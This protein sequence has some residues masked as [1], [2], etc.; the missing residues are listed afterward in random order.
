MERLPKTHVFVFFCGNQKKNEFKKEHKEF[1]KNQQDQVK[2]EEESEWKSDDTLR[3]LSK[4]SGREH[5]VWT[6]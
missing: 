6:C 3:K 5:G 4:I 1:F 2:I